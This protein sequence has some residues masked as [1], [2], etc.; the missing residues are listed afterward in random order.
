MYGINEVLNYVPL[1]ESVE[2]VRTGI[3]RVLPDEFWT[4]TENVPGN[5]ARH[6]KYTGTRKVARVAPYGSPPR[7]VEHLPLEDQPMIFLH[8]IEE[9]AFRQELLDILRQWEDYRPQQKFALDEIARQGEHFRRR[10]DNL[11]TA[12][13]L[14]TLA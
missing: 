9:I 3:P 14:S 11:R 8:T 1:T 13:V 10:F 6:I 4:T 2:A 7:Q 5:K 12:A